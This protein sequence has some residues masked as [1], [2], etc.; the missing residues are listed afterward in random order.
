MLLSSC[1]NLRTKLLFFAIV[2]GVRGIKQS[3]FD[4]AIPP[5]NLDIK[6]SAINLVVSEDED[7]SRVATRAGDPF[8]LLCLPFPIIDFS[9]HFHSTFTTQ[10]WRFR[11]SINGSCRNFG[12]KSC[13]SSSIWASTGFDIFIRLFGRMGLAFWSSQIATQSCNWTN[14]ARQADR[15]T[16]IRLDLSRSYGLDGSHLHINFHFGSLRQLVSQLQ[17]ISFAD[18]QAIRLLTFSFWTFDL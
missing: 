3:G 9:F 18:E 2:L 4:T 8:S 11:S 14:Q 16:G 7:G 13:D 17:S 1:F 12:T 15:R 6:Q 5:L 10:D